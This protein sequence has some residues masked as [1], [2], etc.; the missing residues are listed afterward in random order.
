MGRFE[1]FIVLFALAAQFYT[2]TVRSQK[3]SEATVP[4][5][6]R[7]VGFY[8]TDDT[9]E[10]LYCPATAKFVSDVTV[11]GLTRTYAYCD[12]NPEWWAAGTSCEGNSAHYNGWKST[13]TDMD[14]VQNCTGGPCITVTLYEYYKGGT[15]SRPQYMI[16]CQ[17][18]LGIDNDAIETVFLEQPPTTSTTAADTSTSLAR[19]R[20]SEPTATDDPKDEEN[21]GETN[22]GTNA[23]VIAGAVVGSVVAFCLIA[24][25]IALAFRLGRRSQRD[26][27]QPTAPKTFMETLRSL[28]RPTITKPS[29]TWTN[30]QPNAPPPMIQPIAVENKAE[31]KGDEPA[32][33]QAASPGPQFQ[34]R[35][36]IQG[37]SATNREAQPS[38]RPVLTVTAGAQL[39][40]GPGSQELPGTDVH[41]QSYEMDA[42][43]YRS[44]GN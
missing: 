9:I 17:D 37:N 23:G 20:P 10:T 7:L 38:A 30:P 43:S 31:L 5:S 16:S 21:K 25:G 18:S 34:A 36:S 12:N 19:S 26:A 42:T 44:P 15:G 13:G 32:A 33:Q 11:E 27:E 6:S 2:S 22:S 41:P 14:G 8:V 3:T 1:E 24:G 39:P 4:L 40:T 29:I 28:P 35:P